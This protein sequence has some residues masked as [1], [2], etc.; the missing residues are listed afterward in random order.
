M[1]QVSPFEAAAAAET[2]TEVV[3]EV[4]AEATSAL[5]ACL[6]VGIAVVDPRCVSLFLAKVLPVTEFLQVE[7]PLVVGQAVG[8][9]ALEM[10]YHPSEASPSS[11]EILLDLPN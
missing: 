4:V 1:T 6:A 3:A 10:K 8:Q 11:Y 9:V 7:R 2:E 5:S